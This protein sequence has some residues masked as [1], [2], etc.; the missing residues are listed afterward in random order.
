MS[1]AD[2]AVLGS[3]ATAALC[4]VLYR[5]Y[6]VRSPTVSIGFVAMLAS[7]A[8]LVVPAFTLGSAATIALG[9]PGWIVVA[10]IGI[11][12]AVGYF[13]WLWALRVDGATEVTMFLALSPLTAAALGVLILAEPLGPRLLVGLVL[14]IGGLW[15]AQR[16]AG[17]PAVA[18]S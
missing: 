2:L 11:S 16:R 7:V 14:V 5:P 13:A 9:A 17:R 15:L 8:A 4:G 18:S 3:A 10:G 6:L 1:L 12:S